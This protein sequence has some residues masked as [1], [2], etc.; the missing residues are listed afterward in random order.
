MTE[1]SYH[2]RLQTQHIM[3]STTSHNIMPSHYRTHQFA[4]HVQEHL[5]SPE[6]LQIRRSRLAEHG[7]LHTEEN[8]FSSISY[9]GSSEPAWDTTQ[10]TQLTHCGTAA[11]Q[12]T[13]AAVRLL[14][15]VLDS[16]HASPRPAFKSSSGS[17]GHAAGGAVGNVE[18]GAGRSSQDPPGAAALSPGVKGQSAPAMASAEQQQH[19]QQL[20]EEQSASAALP[21][22]APAA[23]QGMPVH[24]QSAC[25][26][27]PATEVQDD[28]NLDLPVI[29]AQ[30]RIP[31]KRGAWRQKRAPC[32]QAG[33][34]AVSPAVPVTGH[35]T[36]GHKQSKQRSGAAKPSQPQAN[37][38]F[39]GSAGLHTDKA[40]ELAE[41][42]N[43]E[44]QLLVQPAAVSPTQGLQL[45]L[46]CQAS[47][48]N[49]QVTNGPACNSPQCNCPPC[50]HPPCDNTMTDADV[51]SPQQLQLCL[52]TQL[53]N[54]APG[55]GTSPAR[56]TSWLGGGWS[57]P[58]EPTS[59]V[60]NLALPLHGASRLA[61][62]QQLPYFTCEVAGKHHTEGTE[63][64]PSGIR[65]PRGLS[66]T[67]LVD[68]TS[69]GSGTTLLKGTPASSPTPV[70]LA[71]PATTAC[72]GPGPNEVQMVDDSDE[73]LMELPRPHGPP[74]KGFVAAHMFPCS[75]PAEDNFSREQSA[76][77]CDAEG[78]KHSSPLVVKLAQ[79]TGRTRTDVAE[80]L[81]NKTGLW[82]PSKR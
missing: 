24:K 78:S 58:Q 80:Q 82:G 31:T 67:P 61:S 3:S 51:T 39:K 37:N 38:S 10:A 73:G 74:S 17:N 12:L 15:Q 20:P 32:Q 28:G 4:L 72:K 81:A 79:P 34:E 42:G 9:M 33:M 63:V 55:N 65:P 18:A 36:D 64:T 60:P 77:A 71:K 48:V 7:S 26:D 69:G 47:P 2:G 29:A 22:N 75:S 5:C 21:C 68:P 16:G 62:S 45:R 56:L 11:E 52:D 23:Q 46:T 1:I 44:G 57:V 27:I 43:T 70:G 41:P 49:K 50:N 76:A 8:T 19:L 14:S 35:G 40:A 53:P 54:Q 25:A 30:E 66:A 13:A 6:Q 59:A